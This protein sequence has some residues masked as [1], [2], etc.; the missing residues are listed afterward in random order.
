MCIPISLMTRVR[1]INTCQPDAYPPTHSRAKEAFHGAVCGLSW[2]AGTLAIRNEQ[3]LSQF[4]CCDVSS[5]VGVQFAS[6]RT[7]ESIVVLSNDEQ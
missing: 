7:F 6:G 1:G 4:H 2:E 3:E 5:P